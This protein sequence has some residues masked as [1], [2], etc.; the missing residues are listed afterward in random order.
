MRAISAMVC[1]GSVPEVV[2]AEAEHRVAG[3]RPV[4][5]LR[6]LSRITRAADCRGTA[7]VGF[8]DQSLLAPEEVDLEDSRRRCLNFPLHL[9]DRKAACCVSNGQQLR[10]HDAAQARSA[11][12]APPVFEDR[13]QLSGC[14]AGAVRRGSG[15]SPGRR[16]RRARPPARS[17]SASAPGRCPRR[18]RSSGTGSSLERPMHSHFRAAGGGDEAAADALDLAT[19]FDRR[20]HVDFRRLRTPTGPGRMPRS[21]VRRR[22]PGPQ[23]SV[24]AMAPPCARRPP[25]ARPQRPRGRQGAACPQA[26]RTGDRD[27]D[28]S[29]AIRSWLRVRRL[30]AAAPRFARPPTRDSLP[31]FLMVAMPR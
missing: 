26:D 31:L 14:P 23:A 28:S 16:A 20:D 12:V 18:R 6:R 25:D 19:R 5:R 21:R 29:P 24:A 13:A 8:D 2:L 10:L 22:V 30:R 7:A 9:R 27:L 3:L 11:L 1:S 17:G 15:R 4:R